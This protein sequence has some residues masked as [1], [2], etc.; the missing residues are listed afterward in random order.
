MRN[1]FEEW[2]DYLGKVVPKGADEV[3]VEEC[4]RAFYAGAWAFYCLMME[5]SAHRDEAQCEREIGGLRDEVYWVLG[6]LR[7]ERRFR[8]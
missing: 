8:G 7:L 1:V 6:D 5:A 4:R 3:Q 2:T